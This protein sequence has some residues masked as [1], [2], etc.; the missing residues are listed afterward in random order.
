MS[1]EAR[2][3]GPVARLLSPFRE[4]GV[5]AGLLYLIDRALQRISPRLGLNVYELMVQ[6]ITDKALLPAGLAKNLEF[7]EI[8]EG[9]PEIALMPAR[10]EIKEARFRQNAQCLGVYRTEQLIGYLWFCFDSYNE[11]EVR[12]TFVLPPGR[13]SVFDFDLYVMPER[14]LGIGFAAVWHGANRYLWEQGVR[15]T[16]SRLT[17]FNTASRRS[18]A[19]LGWE[20]VGLALFLKIWGVE[21]MCSTVSPFFG[22]TFRSGQRLRLVLKPDALIEKQRRSTATA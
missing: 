21:L 12:C 14:R 13:T 11:D 15:H 4:F 19:H 10:D 17:R 8:R 3:V 20:R 6:P 9:D 5:G 7:R 16:F 2:A 22:M 1:P 18:H